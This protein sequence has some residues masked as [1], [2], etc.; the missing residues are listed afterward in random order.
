M[1][2]D[3]N[4]FGPSVENPG[5]V[6]NQKLPEDTFS[7]VL[8][9]D[10]N[11]AEVS[12]ARNQILSQQKTS[13]INPKE[14]DFEFIREHGM[15]A[16]VEEVH[17]QKIEELREKLLQAM[18][19]TE[20]SLSE[21]PADQRLAIE[22]MIAHEIEKRMAAESMINGGPERQGQ[23]MKTASVGGI[24]SQNLLAAQIMS[25]DTG[26]LVGM[27]ISDASEGTDVINQNNDEDDA[28]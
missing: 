8:N 14:G 21:L 17:K 11:K 28:G 1:K 19:L 4:Q 12:A 6:I 10:R 5:Q 2:I 16:Y 13:K 15:R 23:N 20:E 27:T 9:A 26:T 18:G 24:N 22:K 3:N 7:K 25:G